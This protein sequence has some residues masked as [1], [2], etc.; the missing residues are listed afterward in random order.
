MYHVGE[1]VIVMSSP[2]H[3]IIVEID[4]NVLTI[5]NQQGIKKQVF[6][7]AVRKRE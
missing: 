6:E 3:F 5:E 4:G 2:G 1:E 7:Q